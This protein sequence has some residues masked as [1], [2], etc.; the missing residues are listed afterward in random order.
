[1]GF[2]GYCQGLT[3]RLGRAAAGRVA[4][5]YAGVMTELRGA[6]RGFPALQPPTRPPITVATIR[7]HA[8]RISD[9]AKDL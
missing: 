2:L 9:L 3:D 4:Q 6:Q 7:G 8:A 5:A 1:M